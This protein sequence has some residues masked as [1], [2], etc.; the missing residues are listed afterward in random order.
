MKIIEMTATFGCLDHAVLR[1]GEGFTL[2][3]ANNESGKSTWAAFLRAM[4][5]GF[6]PR[7]RDKA[8]YLAEKNRYQPWSGAPME[9]SLTLE[10]QG[11]RLTL[12]RG[13]KGTT[14]WGAFSAV[15]TATGENVEGLTAE[16]CGET[17]LGV[18]REVFERTAFVEQGQMALTPSSHLEMRVAALATT[19]EEDVSFSQVERRL[20]D[21]LNRRK[22]NSRVGLIPQ[23][24][25]EL[26][27]VEEAISQQGDLLRRSQ[28][29]LQEKESL[30]QEKAAL[31]A[32][33]QAHKAAG[34]ARQ[35]ERRS[36]AQADFDAAQA[37][38]TAAEAAVKALPDAEILR[39]AQ[40]DLR[41]LNTLES[42][43]KLAE[44][45]IPQARQQAEQTRQDADSDPWFPGQ[46]PA[47]AAAQAQSHRDQAEALGKKAPSP[48]LLFLLPLLATAA[49]TLYCYLTYSADVLTSAPWY[50]GV[51]PFAPPLFLLTGA[52]VLILLLR[53]RKKRAA[54]AALLAQY[55]AQTPGEILDRSAS[56]GKKVAAAQEAARRLQSVEDQRDKLAAQKEELSDRLLRLVYPFAPEV[57]NLFGVST[58]L[59]RALQ[60]EEGY[61]LAK[62]R[63]EAAE[64]L[65]SALPAPD[66]GGALPFSP[67]AAPEGDPALLSR[68]LAAVTAHL[69]QASDESARLRGRLSS[70]GDPAELEA[71]RD[72]LT[73]QLALRRGEFDAISA[74][75]EGLKAADS[76]LRERF[77]PAV[78]EKAGTYLSALTGGKYDAVTLTRQFQ[79]LAKEAGETAPHPDLALSG[80]A[81]QQLYL[82]V[83]LAMC[84]LALPGADPC[85]LLLDDTLDAF[86]DHRAKLA[87]DCLLKLAEHRQVLLFT[88]H[89]REEKMLEGQPVTIIK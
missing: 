5:Y 52:A 27:Q 36:Q 74:A 4:L 45:D 21:W 1:P 49:M 69:S 46:D 68:E 7:D 83:R 54:L 24:E 23:L 79:A 6:P 18:S 70:L 64:K 28:E 20:K 77:S 26:S 66:P 61:H 60:Q 65:L 16:T 13:P 88:C 87:L 86:D 81:S 57:T 75:L 34:A 43:L 9:G 14:A 58:A 37:Q 55:N 35:A 19:G 15:W 80:G 8:G 56:Y 63:A 78:N 53:R 76:L 72:A 48:L 41:Y 25:G 39:Q 17:L 44:K 29:A 31:E 89:T 11:R 59:S 30:E 42:N 67:A 84:D 62:A 32:R 10:W 2:I 33:L 12:R 51:Q 3:M 22:V 40:G 71:R 82:A 38:L 85:P 73:E 47:Q 50:A